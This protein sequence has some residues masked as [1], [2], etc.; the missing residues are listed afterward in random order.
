MA[1]P[2]QRFS[3]SGAAVPSS[4]A[5]NLSISGVSFVLTQIAGW[6]TGAG[7]QPFWVVIDP[8][9]AAEEHILCSS[10]S[11]GNVNVASGGR[12]GDGTVP[13]AHQAG[14]VVE[15]IFTGVEADD[16]N[17]HIYDATRDD[18]ARYA[19]VNGSRPFTGLVTFQAGITDTGPLTQTG[20]VTI[21]GNE[22]VSGS[23]GVGGLAT[24][25]AGANVTGN[26]AVSGD[27]SGRS[28]ALSGLTG[29]TTPSRYVGAT[30]GA[31]P[32]TGTFAVGDY[33]IGTNGTVW[34]CTAA[35]SPGTWVV[36]IPAS[37]PRGWIGSALGNAVDGTSN[38]TIV[39]LPVPLVSGRRYRVSAHAIA[40]QITSAGAITTAQLADTA[41]YIAVNVWRLFSATAAPLNS[42]LAGAAVYTF[43]ATATATDTFSVVANAT[44][45]AVRFL[46]NQSQIE[47]EDIGG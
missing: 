6:P 10:Q 38:S 23:L 18:H 13:I 35:G 27:I 29:A 25:G 47:V 2:L 37:Y 20:P 17:A 40:T 31:A 44:A 19:P 1:G 15:H 36:A 32:T 42:A 26:A 43:Q 16:A 45:G 24:L 22:T 14:A 21:T 28:L 9:N 41:G 7:G 33:V 4:L 5:S 46:V 3:H 11:S 30:T 12:G 39:A 8:G 34:V